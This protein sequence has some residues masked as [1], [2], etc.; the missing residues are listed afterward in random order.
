MDQK[1]YNLDEG[2]NEY[3][4]FSVRGHVYKFRYMTVE[5]IEKMQTLTNNNDIMDYVFTF[6]SKVDEKSPEFATIA[7]KF[8]P[9]QLK[10][11]K[12]MIVAQFTQ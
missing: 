6:I 5:E 11:F 4:E 10:N 9:P 1:V 8:T 3:F 2:V 12:D 7:K